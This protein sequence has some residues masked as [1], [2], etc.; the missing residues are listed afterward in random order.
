M[1]LVTNSDHTVKSI[2]DNEF[3]SG[4]W[5]FK[6]V[7]HDWMCVRDV[8]GA[9][10]GDAVV[11]VGRSGEV[12]PSSGDCSDKW[13]VRTFPGSKFSNFQQHATLSPE[14]KTCSQCQSEPGLK[15]HFLCATDRCIL[16]PTS[17]ECTA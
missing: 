7:G 9:S 6:Q 14:K 16:T 4:R 10:S 15:G 8:E 5:Q 11:H 2:E 3:V 12:V 13:T 17:L 1:N